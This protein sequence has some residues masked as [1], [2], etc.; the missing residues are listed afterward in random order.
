MNVGQICSIWNK[1]AISHLF[2]FHELIYD[3]ELINMIWRK[4]T[5]KLFS[6][7]YFHYF[8]FFFSKF[9]IPFL[10]LILTEYVS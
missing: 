7:V 6:D 5:K 3:D 1:K 4:N 8:W 10:L 2:V 9:V